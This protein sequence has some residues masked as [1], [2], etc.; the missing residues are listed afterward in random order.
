[1]C[2]IGQMGEVRWIRQIGEISVIGG[3]GH[4]EL[5]H[6]QKNGI[7]LDPVDSLVHLFRWVPHLF[8]RSSS[9]F[10]SRS[11]S[12]SCSRVCSRSSSRACSRPFSRVF[13]RL[14][15]R[16]FSRVSSR[17]Y[18]PQLRLG[19]LCRLRDGRPPFWVWIEHRVDLGGG[20]RGGG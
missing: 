5:I 19:T 8:S 18:P 9:R 3:I 10:F 16:F 2:R 6:L 20:V 1:M 7:Q 17:L 4:L 12:R 15:S 14:S 11:C 13:S